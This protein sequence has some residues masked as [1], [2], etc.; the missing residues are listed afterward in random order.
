MSF[1]PGTHFT[2]GETEA[3]RLQGGGAHT[4][5][6]QAGTAA[7]AAAGEVTHTNPP[8]ANHQK[9]R[10]NI[11]VQ[12]RRG[13]LLKDSGKLRMQGRITK[14]KSRRRKPRETGLGSGVVLPEPSANARDSWE[15][16][17]QLRGAGGQK[18]ESKAHAVNPTGGDL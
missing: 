17:C 2:G 10:Q 1:F 14:P 13:M 8:T 16:L 12:G 11:E 7:S 9:R 3:R 15:S 5:T 4:E 6:E 18:S